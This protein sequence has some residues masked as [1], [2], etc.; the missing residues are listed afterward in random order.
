MLG[1]I[2]AA[3]FEW[4]IGLP[5]SSTNCFQSC[6]ERSLD[7]VPFSNNNP[8]VSSPPHTRTNLCMKKILGRTK[9][10][11]AK[12]NRT[13]SLFS[14]KK[15]KIQI[16]NKLKLYR[17]AVILSHIFSAKNQDEQP[18]KIGSYR[19]QLFSWNETSST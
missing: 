12:N 10:F 17:K 19:Q 14:S 15:A 9:K 3:S 11:A 7:Q 5:P 2:V 16:R 8:P 4:F 6:E 18:Q 13:F 1:V